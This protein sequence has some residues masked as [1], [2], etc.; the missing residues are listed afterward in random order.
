M[1]TAM[2]ATQA[3]VKACAGKGTCKEAGCQGC[4]TC[5]SDSSSWES[6]GAP[7]CRGDQRLRCQVRCC[8]YLACNAVLWDQQWL[9]Q[10]MKASTANP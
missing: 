5:Q 8:L 3:L 2:H 6:R 7:A 4:S 1:H 9:L 10:D